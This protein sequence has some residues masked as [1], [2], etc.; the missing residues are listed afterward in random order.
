MNPFAAAVLSC[1]ILALYIVIGLLSNFSWL[2]LALMSASQYRSYPMSGS[3]GNPSLYD[4]PILLQFLLPSLL[5]IV[6]ALFLW[7][8]AG[9]LARL[10]TAGMDGGTVPVMGNDIQRIL[11]ALIGVFVLVTTIPEAGRAIAFA[12]LSASNPVQ[13]PDNIMKS[14]PENWALLLRF[15]LGLGLLFG[16]SALSRRL[17]NWRSL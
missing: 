17:D 7:I 13:H 10:I 5:Q 6:F 9:W 14:V 2:P 12:L 3:P 15:A 11:L 8:K 1:R 4:L 16:A